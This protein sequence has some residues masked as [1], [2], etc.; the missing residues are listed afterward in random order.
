MYQRIDLIIIFLISL[1]I[2]LIIHRIRK[3]NPTILNHIIKI[4]FDAVHYGIRSFNR[5]GFLRTSTSRWT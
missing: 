1:G 2:G 5:G 3:K 4:I